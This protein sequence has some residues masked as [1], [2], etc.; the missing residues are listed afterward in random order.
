MK[1]SYIECFNRRVREFPENEAVG[2]AR[3]LLT[4]AQL[5]CLSDAIGALVAQSLGDVP[6][7]RVAVALSR[8]K[9]FFA[10]IFGVMKAG[11]AY[12]P[13]EPDYPDE[14]IFDILDESKCAVAIVD[15]VFLDAHPDVRLR[16][17]SD[18]L[19]ELDGERLEQA[20]LARAVPPCG[21]FDPLQEGAIYYTSGSTGRPKGV[22]RRAQQHS[23]FPIAKGSKL[24][25]AETRY[26]CM[27]RFSFFA[28]VCLSLPPLAAGGF[29]YVVDKD[30]MLDLDSVAATFC[31]RRITNAFVAP[32]LA[33]PLLEAYP[34]LPLSALI[35]AGESSASI[36][37]VSFPLFDLYG[38]TECPNVL[39]HRIDAPG[40][41]GLMGEPLEGIG[42]YLVD[43]DGSLVEE[44]GIP[45]ELCVDNPHL[46]IGYLNRPDEERAKFCEFAFAP[47]K[48][49]FRMGDLVEW[50]DTPRG[51]RLRYVG[52]SDNMVKLNGQRVELEEVERTVIATGLVDD[53]LCAVRDANGVGVLFCSYVGR[54]EL[55]ASELTAMRDE[56]AKTLPP[57]ML[58]SRFVRIKEIPRNANGK[59]DRHAPTEELVSERNQVLPANEIE[60]LIFDA[61]KEIIGDDI[62]LSVTD[63]LMS[64]GMNSLNLM[65]LS[66]LLK[67]RKLEMRPTDAMRFRSIR[68]LAKGTSSIA[69]FYT[70]YDIEKPTLVL[71]CGIVTVDE[72]MHLIKPLDEVFN[73]LVIE[74][75]YAH[76]DDLFDERDFDALIRFYMELM[77]DVLPDGAEPCGFFGISFG[78]D[79]A[80]NLAREWEAKTGNQ[81]PVL[82]GDTYVGVQRSLSV[83]E[84]ASEGRDLPVPPEVVAYK[85]NLVCDLNSTRDSLKSYEG[86]VAFLNTPKNYDPQMTQEKLQTAKRLFPNLSLIDLPDATH[87]DLYLSEDL[88]ETILEAAKIHLLPSDEA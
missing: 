34:S 67:Q 51:R 40:E 72:Y 36:P 7:R 17:E 82:M 10:A 81:L 18:S 23:Y 9:E 61:V 45:G 69:W 49:L 5:G 21:L 56:L 22:V 88:T 77:E 37:D 24:M 4:Y 62:P 1:E 86:H 84:I 38:S 76:Y 14:R 11:G 70:P 44:S 32:R 29:V 52:R 8:R 31:E 73:V 30:E 48:R 58:P 28:S 6:V 33:V 83:E 12:V 26:A 27:G 43:E 35:V 60:Q 46:A 3:G 78:G 55:S 53:A 19:L 71:V 87:E 42:L 41:M 50:V 16:F 74:S 63:D 13:I 15:R 65:R 59:L 66:S 39:A 85:L 68:N 75:T 79:I 47:G 64:V 54:S 20:L 25:D 80:Y 2:D 57:Y